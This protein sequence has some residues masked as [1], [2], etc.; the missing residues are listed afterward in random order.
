MLLAAI[1][2]ASPVAARAARYDVIYRFTAPP[3]GVRPQ[4][5]LVADAKGDLYGTTFTGSPKG[6]G[7]VYRL[8]PR[9]NGGRSWREKVIFHF[10]RPADGEYPQS[11]LIF[12]GAG[13]LYGMTPAG[14]P[15]GSGVVF[16]LSPPAGGEGEWSETILHNFGVR[17]DGAE[18]Y[19]GLV[20][21]PDGSLYGTTSFGGANASG[22]VFRLTPD[23][24]SG[25]WNETIIF[26]FA[27][28]PDGGYPYAT[29]AFDAS[30]ALYGPTLNGGN[31][32]NG[33]VFQLTPP[34]SGT[35][36]NEAVLHSF[37]APGDGQM[38]RE[39]VTLD[40]AGNVFGTTEVGGANNWGVAYEVS[41]PSGGSGPWTER[42]IHSFNEDNGGG[43]P[44]Y[45]TLLRDSSGILYGTSSHPGQG[46]SN[47]TVFS[48]TPPVNGG[49]WLH[50]D[51]HRFDGGTDGLTP[52]AGL[53]L[54]ADGKLAGT[55]FF[56]GNSA[57]A[58]VVFQITP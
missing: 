9:S 21:G 24:H 3:N 11:A 48:L 25:T 22:T 32:G 50:K 6:Y 51:L 8:S 16:E 23:Q 13:N 28:G 26:N 44:T 42:V 38:P 19:G 15:K 33:V 54:T 56:G 57:E 41:P 12:D 47:G 17:S 2:A 14:G 18:P 30:G 36:W 31:S 37:D 55:T 58:G 53:I 35:L 1:V 27:N 10:R 52:E 20:F 34:S 29:L 7:T 40:P 4:G 46:T 39:G 43:G 5:P 45:S 49:R